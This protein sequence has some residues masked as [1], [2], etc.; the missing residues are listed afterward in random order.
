MPW[1][2]ETTA[3]R[4]MTPMKT[5]TM[6]KELLS[7]WARSVWKARRMA[8]KNGISCRTVCCRS[9]N[10]PSYNLQPSFIPQRLHRIQPGRLARRVDAEQHAGK[11]RHQQGDDDGADRHVRG[12]VQAD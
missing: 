3:I 8:S 11:R 1:T 10:V 5:P 4:N 6:E 2:T 9:Y 12:E 7:F